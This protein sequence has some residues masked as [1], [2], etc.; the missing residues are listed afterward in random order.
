[1]PL[2]LG[3]YLVPYKLSSNRFYF[4]EIYNLVIILP[5]RFIA[6]AAYVIDRFLIDATVNLFGKVPRMFGSLMRSLQMGLVHFYALAMV[7]GVL[8]L[9]AARMMWAD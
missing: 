2:A 1:M 4:D 9:V 3:N 8:V 7:L 5:L 6:E